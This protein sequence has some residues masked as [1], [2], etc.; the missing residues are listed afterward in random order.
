[1]Q[2]SSKLIKKILPKVHKVLLNVLEMYSVSIFGP[3]IRKI[4]LNSRTHRRIFRFFLSN[5]YT[6][7]TFFVL[8]K[9]LVIFSLSLLNRQWL[10]SKR[11]GFFM[12]LFAETCLKCL[13][14][15]FFMNNKVSW[16]YGDQ[17]DVKTNF[18]LLQEISNKLFWWDVLSYYGKYWQYF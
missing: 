7:Q 18:S 6:S 1:M 3:G 2:I 9:S 11:M 16:W 15:C 5:S 13:F 14:F 12:N 10:T 17:I 8:T 4:K